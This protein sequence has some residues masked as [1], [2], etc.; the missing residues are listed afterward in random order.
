MHTAIGTSLAAMVFTGVVAVY[1]FHKHQGIIWATF[2]A[3]IP[4]I[5]I[6]SVLGALI[7][8]FL[9]GVVLEIFFGV[10]ICLLGFYLYFR[11]KIRNK[12]LKLPI[13]A[14]AYYGFGIA[15]I[16]SLLGIGG[17]VFIVPLLI[18]HGIVEKKAIGTSAVC[19]LCITFFGALSYLYFGLGHVPVQESIGYIYLPAFV[20]IGL[21]AVFFVPLGVKMVQKI[22]GITLRKVFAGVLFLT[23]LL[24]IFF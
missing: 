5:I 11:R 22:P 6:G 10:F 20:L 3:M 21:T 14:Y 15:C 23:G 19:S 2:K 12:E 4:G 1:F 7:G 17:G 18:H 13:F 16:A 24:M 9:S 8:H